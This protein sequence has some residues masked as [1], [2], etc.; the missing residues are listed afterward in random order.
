MGYTFNSK[1]FSLAE[2]HPMSRDRFETA[3]ENLEKIKFSA[4]NSSR[5]EH[6]IIDLVD[7]K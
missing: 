7:I 2:K 3:K 5:I 4:E 1:I 6:R